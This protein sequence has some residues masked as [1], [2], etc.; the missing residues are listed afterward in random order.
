MKFLISKDEIIAYKE[1]IWDAM[2][3][4]EFIPS[5]FD[6]CG[7]RNVEKYEEELGC[8]TLEDV[9]VYIKL[10]N[11]EID[12]GYNDV[13]VYQ[14]FVIFRK[15]DYQSLKDQAAVREDKTAV[16]TIDALRVFYLDNTFCLK[17][18]TEKG[19]ITIEVHATK[20]GPEIRVVSAYL[21]WHSGYD[22]A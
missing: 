15:S 19:K 13:E 21:H 2:D 4:G 22:F 12:T 17:D 1:R 16:G 9:C 7:L 5:H 6:N 18:E 11:Y 10:D 3:V 14:E 20:E 8:A